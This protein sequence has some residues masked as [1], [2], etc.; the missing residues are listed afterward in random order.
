MS[1]SVPL[2]QWVEFVSHGHMK[3]ALKIFLI[4]KIR[5]RLLEEMMMKA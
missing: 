1:Y 2:M 5:A 4:R 3:L